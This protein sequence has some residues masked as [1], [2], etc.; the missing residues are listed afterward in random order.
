MSEKK[1]DQLLRDIKKLAIMM[2]NAAE[3]VAVLTHYDADGLASGGATARFLSKT[4]KLFILRSTASLSED[5]LN[6][7]F[8]IRAKTYVIQ[9]M[10]SGD[11]KMI[12]SKWKNTNSKLLVIIDH[13][14]IL[15]EPPQDKR[16]VIVNPEMY[17]ID[18]GRIGCTSV[19]ASLM[20]YYGLGERD[21]YFLEIGVVGAAGDMQMQNG[22]VGVNEYLLRLA[23]G[24]GIVKKETEFVFF[25]LRRLPVFKAIVWNLVPYIPGFS[26][27]EDIGLNI[28]RKAGIR[29]RNRSGEYVTVAELTEEEKTRILEVIIKYIASLG[30]DG[31]SSNDFLVD[32][33]YLPLEEDPYLQTAI[34]FSNMISSCGRMDREDVGIAL[35][36]GSRGEILMEAK[37]IIEERRKILG[38]YL[39]MAERSIKIYDG[40]L[41]I[42]D[43]TEKDFSVKFSGTISTIFS[44]SLTYGDK[45]ILV[46]S[47]DEAGDIHLSSRAPRKLV[48]KGL[49]LSKIMR[50][51]SEELGGRGGGHNIAAGAT[52]PVEDSS[53]IIEKIREY[54]KEEI[55][56]IEG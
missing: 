36:A 18:G 26:N 56:R 7:F 30:I 52:I 54:I 29:I 34:E 12:Y 32:V 28:V 17:G 53:K 22:A 4:E 39:D 49:D 45:I 3:P 24:K 15:E 2:S 33:L 50:K 41:V 35:S 21:P 11:L 6:A 19:L 23:E 51:I 13:H 47:S 20:G 10:G 16:V 55:A 42:V 38:K 8:S 5:V 1:T 46:L 43:L 9:D 48:D 37:K 44:R 25:T 14:K 27:R 40:M 31:L